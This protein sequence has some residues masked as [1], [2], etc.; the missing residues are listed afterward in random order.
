MIIYQDR[1]GTK[2]VHYEGNKL[3]SRRLS[4]SLPYDAT[5]QMH[6]EFEGMPFKGFEAKQADTLMLQYPLMFNHSTLT[7]VSK[8]NDLLFYA[9]HSLIS[10]DMTQAIYSKKRAR[11]A[12]PPPSPLVTSL[13]P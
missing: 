5:A 6:P 12:P 10:P 1:L 7:N 3:V 13:P 11:P 4:P 9:N 8:L 2:K